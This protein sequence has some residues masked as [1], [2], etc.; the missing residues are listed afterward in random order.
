[1][2]TNRVALSRN[3]ETSQTAKACS[4]VGGEAAAGRPPA[5]VEAGGHRGEHAREVELL[6]GEEGG[7]A[8]EQA[9]GDLGRRVVE[10]AAD[11]ADHDPTARPT[12]RRPTAA[13]TNSRLA[14]SS[15]KL[16]ATAAATATR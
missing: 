5:E 1:M 16:P 10:P 12:R 3:V 6:G 2:R 15:E 11:L 13:S 14:S 9:D 4:R 8:G 7:V